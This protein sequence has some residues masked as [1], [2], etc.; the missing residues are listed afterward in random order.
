[1]SDLHSKLMAPA[2]AGPGSSEGL[3]LSPM[4]QLLAFVDWEA[5]HNPGK[6]HIAAWAADEIERL[7]GIA[8]DNFSAAVDAL[9]GQQSAVAAAVTA[10]RNRCVAHVREFA[11]L[12]SGAAE[13]AAVR[14]AERLESGA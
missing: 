2:D 13:V 12:R 7:S 11:N 9:D 10:E 3:G 8:R 4:E 5:K 14:L 6:R 1:M